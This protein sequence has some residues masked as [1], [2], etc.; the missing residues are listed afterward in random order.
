[1]IFKKKRKKKIKPEIRVRTRCPKCLSKMDIVDSKRVQWFKL[2]KIKCVM[3]GFEHP[4]IET[5]K[6]HYNTNRSRWDES[7]I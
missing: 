6:S 2:H 7:R 5:N 4:I 3:C 1:M